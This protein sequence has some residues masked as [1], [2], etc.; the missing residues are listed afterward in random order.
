MI[1]N[2]HVYD[3]WS[4]G[5]F[6]EISHDATV[7][8]NTVYGNGFRSFRGSCP[9]A[10]MYA[11]G[12]TVAASDNVSVTGNTVTGNCNGITATQ[13]PRPDGN[14]GLLQNVN[15]QHNTIAGPGGKTGAAVYPVNIANLALRS[16]TFANNTTSNGM[17]ACGL[18][19]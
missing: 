7:T 18:L 14:P 3:N 5:I 10:W 13:E 4:E 12:I 15:V 6:I 1:T 19:C 17:N 9:N 2:N 8:G 11:G 16:I